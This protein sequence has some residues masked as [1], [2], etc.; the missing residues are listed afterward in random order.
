VQL[1]FQD[2]HTV[3]SQQFEHCTCG[4]VLKLLRN[5]NMLILGVPDVS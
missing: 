1:H 2:E 5:A 3:V 4:L